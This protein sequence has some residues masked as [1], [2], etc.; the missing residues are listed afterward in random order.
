MILKEYFKELS[1]PCGCGARSP[2][3]AVEMLYAVRIIMDMPIIVNSSVRC[4]KYNKNVKGSTESM[5]L[6]PGVIEGRQVDIGAFDIVAGS[7]SI[8]RHYEY[9]L[10]QV[11]QSVGFNGVGIRD[12]TFLHTDNR[13]LTPVVWGYSK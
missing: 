11:C 5:H 6:P 9:K 7:K 3:R 2:E 4:L 1:C 8:H 13:H 10:I 12:N